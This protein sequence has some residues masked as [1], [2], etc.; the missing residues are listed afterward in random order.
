MYGKS[1]PSAARARRLKVCRRQGF[2]GLVRGAD[3][4]YSCFTSDNAGLLGKKIYRGKRGGYYWKSAGG[5]KNYLTVK[6]QI[7]NFQTTPYATVQNNYNAP[8]R[9]KKLYRREGEKCYNFLLRNG[10]TSKADYKR[11]ILKHHPDKIG[12]LPEAERRNI[13]NLVKHVNDCISRL[14]K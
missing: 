2:D 4:R 12:H 11:W 6:P 13:T 9:V 14:N 5:F 10:I 1:M 3:N 8:K 7:R